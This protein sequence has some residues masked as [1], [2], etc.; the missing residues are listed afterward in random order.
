MK[1]KLMFELELI[2]TLIA[3]RE[4]AQKDEES[5]IKNA[6]NHGYIMG[7]KNEAEFLMK[8]LREED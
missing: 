7:L 8:T 5:P 3:K 1:K 6:M 4:A 2:N